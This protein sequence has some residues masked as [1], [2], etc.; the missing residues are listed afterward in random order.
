M[1]LLDTNICI[2]A[3]KGERRV[4]AKLTQNVGRIHLGMLVVAYDGLSPAP[5]RRAFGAALSLAVLGQFLG[6][7]TWVPT[8]LPFLLRIA[9]SGT[10][11]I[12]GL[13][14]WDATRGLPRFTLPL[15]ALGRASLTHYMLHIVA[16]FAPLR[17]LYPDEDWPVRVGLCVFFG[18]LTLAFPLTMLWF[19]RFSRGPLESLWAWLSGSP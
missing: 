15:A 16:V 9:S 7:A 1:F 2:A 12:A 10:A 18:Y 8:T 3:L 5:A 19:R 13:L 11:T 14:W 4:L 6:P 17:L